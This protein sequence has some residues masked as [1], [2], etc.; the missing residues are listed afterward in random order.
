[1]R[2]WL[3]VAPVFPFTWEGAEQKGR[4]KKIPVFEFLQIP[5]GTETI[6]SKIHRVKDLIMGWL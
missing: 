1:M 6:N 3:N 4:R 2:D 5:G